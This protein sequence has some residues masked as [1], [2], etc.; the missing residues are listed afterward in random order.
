MLSGFALADRRSLNGLLAATAKDEAESD[1]V[2]REFEQHLCV[3]QSALTAI[4]YRRCF[5]RLF[6]LHKKT[7]SAMASEVF[8]DIVRRMGV[9]HASGYAAVH[10]RDFWQ[11]RAGRARKPHACN[12]KVDPPEDKMLSG[13]ALADR[14]SL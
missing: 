1:A 2:A 9:S 5:L 8:V 12:S 14:R 3:A 7:F 13:F 4:T 10:F 6:G 11:K